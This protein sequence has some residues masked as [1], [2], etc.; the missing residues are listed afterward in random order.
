MKQFLNQ[1][2]RYL[3]EILTYIV[4]F[5]MPILLLMI[6]TFCLVFLDT[7]TG[8]LKAKKLKEKIT[9]RRLGQIVPKL[10]IYFIFIFAGN[11]VEQH[12]VP[13]IPWV[14]FFAGII[15]TV[16]LKS[17]LENASEILG[18]DAFKAM[19]NFISRKQ[20]GITKDSE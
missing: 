3:P 2:Q 19:I 12:M 8:I 6:A 11:I 20:E 16:E 9:S 1:F 10:L 17:I 14:K 18:Y 4:A 5:F 15:G 7:I 13:E